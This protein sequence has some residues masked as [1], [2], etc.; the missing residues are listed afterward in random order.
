[1]GKG[2]GGHGGLNILPGKSWHVWNRD[3]RA[4]VE[5]DEAVAAAK[6][7]AAAEAARQ[8][9]RDARRAEMLSRAGGAEDEEA[10][11]DGEARGAKRRRRSPSPPGDAAPR[12]GHVNF[13]ASAEA[14]AAKAEAAKAPPPDARDA[15]AFDSGNGRGGSS[16]PWYSSPGCSLGKHEARAVGAA[17]RVPLPTRVRAEREADAALRAAQQRPAHSRDG[18]GGSKEAARGGGGDGATAQRGAEAAQTTT[19]VVK[20]GGSKPD[21]AALRA[22]RDAREAA[23]AA[24]AARLVASRSGGGGADGRER[25]PPEKRYHGAYGNARPR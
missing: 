1:M 10:T 21:W 7:A 2:G 20:P 6:D 12:A 19:I 13:F 23:E 25:A 14:A 5:R 8:A 11:G 3:A 9:G 4:R 22:E 15:L 24:R 18:A 17:A 16:V